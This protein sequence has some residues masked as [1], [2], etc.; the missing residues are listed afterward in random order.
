MLSFRYLSEY[1]YGQSVL[2]KKTHTKTTDLTSRH[3]HP[4]A[5]LSP[6]SS[7]SYQ[8][9]V[10]VVCG[11]GNIFSSSHEQREKQT[12]GDPR[13]QVIRNDVPNF[14]QKVYKIYPRLE[15]G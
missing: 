3:L 9:Y 7:H 10:K 4:L 13:K 12:G 2:P 15:L 1:R 6:V 5:P 8:H 14:K 11:D